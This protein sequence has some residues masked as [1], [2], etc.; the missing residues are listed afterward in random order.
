MSSLYYLTPTKTSRLGMLHLLVLNLLPRDR[1]V[2]VWPLNSGLLK[3]YI[4]K[5]GIACL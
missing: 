3:A 5:K 4:F 2:A 1:V